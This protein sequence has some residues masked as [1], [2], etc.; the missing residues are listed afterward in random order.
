MPTLAEA[1]R[2]L[3]VF[4]GLGKQHL[5][6]LWAHLEREGIHPTMYATEW[7]MTMFTR[8]F[9]FDLVTR[10][11]DIYLAE[12]FK[13]VYRVALALLKTIEV[14]LLAS[15]FEDIMMSIRSLPENIDHEVLLV[16]ALTLPVRRDHIAELEAR[17]DREQFEKANKGDVPSLMPP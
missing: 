5:G 17:Y 7:L 12:G 8:G 16:L 15:Q 3:A 6:A 9:S 1:Q 11:W 4:A 2:R 14:Q 13:I 10:V